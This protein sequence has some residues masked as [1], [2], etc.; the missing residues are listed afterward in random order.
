MGVGSRT[1]GRSNLQ[2]TKA[3]EAKCTFQSYLLKVR[4]FIRTETPTKHII[5]LPTP[6]PPLPQCVEGC[7]PVGIKHH[8]ESRAWIS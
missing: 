1:A 2:P 4:L 8:D 3:Q 7:W 5:F 6:P